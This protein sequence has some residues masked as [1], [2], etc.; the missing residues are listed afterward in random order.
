MTYRIIDEWCHHQVLALTSSSHG[1]ARNVV[2]QTRYN[3]IQSF[4]QPQVQLKLEN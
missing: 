1:G 2:L 4:S 3:N